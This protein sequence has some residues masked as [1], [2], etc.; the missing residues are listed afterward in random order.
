MCY[1]VATKS[2]NI[3]SATRHPFK[4]VWLFYFLDA[5]Q[6]IKKCCYREDFYNLEHA[7]KSI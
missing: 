4:H 2:E 5:L 1:S 3:F 6:I 7:K